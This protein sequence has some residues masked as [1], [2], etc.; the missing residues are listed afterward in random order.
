MENIKIAV[1]GPE[2]E[3]NRITNQVSEKQLFFIKQF[4]INI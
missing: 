2:G 1:L 4:T 3:K